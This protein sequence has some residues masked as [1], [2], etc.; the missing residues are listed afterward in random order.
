MFAAPVKF[1]L[2]SGAA[3]GET[4][5]T[6]F[7]KAILQAG[8]GNCNLIKVS[9]ILPSRCRLGQDIIL[10]PGALVPV[11]YGFITSDVPGEVITAAVAVGLAEDPGSYGII[12]EHSGRAPRAVVEAEI[13]RMLEEAFTSR[14]LPLKTVL[15]E[16]V[17]HR[18]VKLGCAFAGVI[19]WY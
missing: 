6:A 14:S 19:L 2:P 15:V 7:D 18:V 13:V 5:L 16:S 10:P 8:V 9:S 4:R 1:K 12:M 17:E 3:E 11:A